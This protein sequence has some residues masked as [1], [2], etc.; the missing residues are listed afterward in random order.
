ML[1]VAE[2]TLVVLEAVVLL[3]MVNLEE[4]EIVQAHL[5]VKVMAVEMVQLM[6]VNI[7]MVAAVAALVVLEH[8]QLLLISLVLEETEHQIQ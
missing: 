4:Q 8:L 3:L 7:M 5:Q 1:T 6:E 2:E